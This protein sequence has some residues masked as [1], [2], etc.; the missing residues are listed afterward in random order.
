MFLRVWHKV[1]SILFLKKII[2]LKF[3]VRLF[4]FVLLLPILSTAYAKPVQPNVELNFFWSHS[5]PHCLEAKPFIESLAKKHTW[6]QLNSYDLLDSPANVERY[7]SMAGK[8]GAAANSVPGFIFC[9]Q[10][11]IGFQ[12][13]EITGK[14][15]EEQLLT[16]YQQGKISLES[17]E[18]FTV[19]VLGEVN[20]QDFSL[21]VFTLIIAALDAFNPCAFFVLFFC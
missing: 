20:Y 9:K 3:I 17:T 8:L 4:I 7:T 13:I 1:H 15:L 18:S 12:S 10:I 2:V 6:L 5:C 14:A 19:P 21:P 16:C 11:S